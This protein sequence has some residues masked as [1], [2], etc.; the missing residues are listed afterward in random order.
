MSHVIDGGV[1]H[2]IVHGD[3][4]DVMREMEDGSVNTVI[5]DPPYNVVNRNG[6]DL[7][8]P[9]Y[10][11]KGS[12]DSAVVDIEAVAT[13]LIRITSGSIYVWCST[14]QASDWRKSFV[15]S[16]L[17]TRQCVWIKSNPAPIN[18]EKMWLSGVELCIFAR[19]PKAPFFEFCKVPAWTGPSEKLDWHPTP[20]PVWLM[21]ELVKASSRKNDIIF[22]PY[23]GSGSVGVA[24]VL[25]ERRFIGVD[26]D[27]SYVDMAR[28]RI[29]RPTSSW[30]RTHD[31]TTCNNQVSLFG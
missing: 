17:T 8:K 20:K 26:I 3:C 4:L 16:G 12:A 21:M 2:D 9:G 14:E 11:D 23:C 10:L 18:G 6:G 31:T 27:K 24:A 28:K 29:A 13:E 5:T 25:L 30:T 19:K 1:A 7:R 22:D 15:N